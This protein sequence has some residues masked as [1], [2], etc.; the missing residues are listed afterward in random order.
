MEILPILL[1]SGSLTNDLA[2]G[3]N[4]FVHIL[5]RVVECKGGTYAHLVAEGTECRLGAVVSG[6][7]RNT[8]FI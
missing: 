1:L 4:Q 8:L 3:N 7:Y 6:T 2:D 5:T